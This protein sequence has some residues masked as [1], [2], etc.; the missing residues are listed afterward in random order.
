M[1]AGMRNNFS[2]GRVLKDL[3][4]YGLS[5]CEITRKIIEGHTPTLRIKSEIEYMFRYPMMY[6]V[7]S[8]FFRHINKYIA[9]K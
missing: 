4:D 9:V 2:A 1:C 7:I 8:F 6:R 5:P 3:R